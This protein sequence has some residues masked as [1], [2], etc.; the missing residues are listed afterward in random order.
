[1]AWVRFP[2]GTRK[3][4]ERVEKTDAQCDLH[5]L[6]S[7]SAVGAAPSVRNVARATFDEIIDE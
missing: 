5:E 1:M 6:T 3:K 7:L 2:D 4:V